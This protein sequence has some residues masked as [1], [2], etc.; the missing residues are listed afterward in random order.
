MIY[1]NYM[2]YQKKYSTEFDDDELNIAVMYLNEG[3]FE[4][5]H[6]II[7]ITNQKGEVLMTE[8]EIWESA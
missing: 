5:Y 6:S 8:D 1:A 4:G 3:V 2:R 7:N